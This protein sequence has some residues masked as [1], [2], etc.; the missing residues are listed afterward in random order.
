MKK[1]HPLYF[2]FA[3]ATISLFT[4]N[5]G[6]DTVPPYDI[7]SHY[8]PCGWMDCGAIDPDA[9]KLDLEYPNVHQSPPS[10]IRI[11]FL[12]CEGKDGSGIYWINN[13]GA[14]DCNW[15]DAP[16]NDF[17][18]EGYTR[19]TFWAKGVQGNEHIKFGIGGVK[20]KGKLHKDSLEAILQVTLSKE[21]KK[22]V[23]DIKD[24]QL[25]SV[26][27]GFYWYAIN[28]DNPDGGT[29]YLDDIQLE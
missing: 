3:F 12:P 24:K 29:F 26:I 7:P 16:G 22:Y 6:S 8:I 20:S 27:G 9:I 11:Q 21:W 28:E 14:G 1:Q 13:R 17:S 15:G 10:S 19:L 4:I 5:C 2:V 23:I 18:T 25:H